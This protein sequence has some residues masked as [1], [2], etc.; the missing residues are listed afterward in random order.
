M[1]NAVVA[2][3]RPITSD[4]L[5]VGLLAHFLLSICAMVLLGILIHKLKPGLAVMGAQDLGC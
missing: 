4:I 3:E 1:G 2:H 5:F